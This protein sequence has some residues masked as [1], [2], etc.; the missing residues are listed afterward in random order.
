[1]TTVLMN[2]GEHKLI[3]IESFH[4][5]GSLKDDLEL[6]SSDLTDLGNVFFKEVFP[7]WSAYI[8]HGGDI[9]KTT[10]LLRG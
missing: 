3:V 8:D 2:L 5:D 7:I 6:R 9:Q 4:V 1:M 10:I